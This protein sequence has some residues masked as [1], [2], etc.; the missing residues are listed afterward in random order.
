MVFEQ[1]ITFS[2]C[3]YFVE[4]KNKIESKRKKIFPKKF[5]LVVDSELFK[6]GSV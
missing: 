3:Y 5:L 4:E 1:T 6:F 2:I